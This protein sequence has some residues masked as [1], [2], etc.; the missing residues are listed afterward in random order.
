MRESVFTVKSS[1]PKV[2]TQIGH[3][4]QWQ[5]AKLFK[6]RNAEL[7]PAYRMKNSDKNKE[8]QAKRMR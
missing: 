5:M 4:I 2:V 1:L 3:F 8:I 7:N 6:R